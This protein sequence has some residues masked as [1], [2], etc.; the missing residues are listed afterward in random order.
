LTLRFIELK[1]WFGLPPDFT[2]EMTGAG[3]ETIDDR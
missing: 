2:M 3:L 1:G